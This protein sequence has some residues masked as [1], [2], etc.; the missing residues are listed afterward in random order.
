LIAQ[1][2]QDAEALQQDVQDAL[3]RSQAEIDSLDEATR[4]MLMEYRGE[5]ERLAR[6]RDYNDNL[7]AMIDSQAEEERRLQQDLQSLEDLRRNL[8]PLMLDMQQ[9]LADFVR[10]DKPF[11]DD[12]RMARV[13]ALAQLQNRA[14]VT[15]AEK[16]RRL[17]EAYIIETEYGQSLEA[18]EGT[19]ELD[20]APR[21]VEFLRLGRTAV[22]YLTLDHERAGF[23]D[24]D[25]A[26]WEDLSRRHVDAIVQG[27]RVARRQ[28]PPDLLHLPL[29]PP[30]AADA[31]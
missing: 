5:I 16:Y 9:A 19:L 2:P 1:T 21:T 31:R 6:L 24:E 12:E 15:L 8:V 20:G 30:E 26:T 28:A 4:D 14:D 11:L 25:T 10:L 3:A 13:S 27:V 29:P 7:Q 18:W 17:I 22:Y 23:W